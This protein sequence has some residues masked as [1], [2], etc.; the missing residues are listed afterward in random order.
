MSLFSGNPKMVGLFKAM[1]ADG[2]NGPNAAA[3]G[4]N[5]GQGAALLHKIMRGV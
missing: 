1:L 2:E 5:S 3:R 4:A